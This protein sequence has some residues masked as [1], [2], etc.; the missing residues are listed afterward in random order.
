MQFLKLRIRNQEVLAVIVPTNP[1]RWIG[2]KLRAAAAGVFLLRDGE[3]ADLGPQGGNRE[4][5]GDTPPG[6]TV[7]SRVLGK[8]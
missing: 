3:T 6:H 5:T 2:P 8:F 4:Q 7:G 1:L